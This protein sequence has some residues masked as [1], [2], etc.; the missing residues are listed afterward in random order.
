MP[1]RRSAPTSRRKPKRPPRELFAI[2]EG[3][4][5]KLDYL[6][7]PYSTPS[8]PL[9]TATITSPPYGNLKNYGHP[10]QIGWGQPYEEYVIELRRIFRSIYNHTRD[11][12]CL[13]V[14]ADSL[15]PAGPN[16]RRLEPLPFQLADEPPVSAGH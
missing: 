8:K 1:P 5:R 9:L 4:S 13:W 12:G 6:L 7:G 11:D 16:V 2:H 14:I 3:D 10:D 15:R